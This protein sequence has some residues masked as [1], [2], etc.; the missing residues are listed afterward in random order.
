MATSA[1][2][3]ADRAELDPQST[4]GDARPRTVT[5]AIVTRIAARTPKAL[6]SSAATT[7]ELSIA[8]DY[9]RQHQE[10]SVGKLVEHLV[11]EACGSIDK[12]IFVSVAHR[13]R[14][15]RGTADGSGLHEFQKL[16]EGYCVWIE[17]VCQKLKL[18]MHGG[19]ACGLV[20]DGSLSP[21]Q[22]PVMTTNASIIVFPQRM[23]MLCHYFCKLLARSLSLRDIT[24]GTEVN[25][26]AKLALA[27]IAANKRL[28]RY[29]L[30][31]IAFN[32]TLNPRFL[33]PLK[34]AKGIARPVWRNLLIGTELFVLAHEYGHHLALHRTEDELD[35][36][37]SPSD[38]AKLQELE[39][40][41]LAAL[42]TAHFGAEAE[43]PIAHSCAAAVVA[44]VGTDIVRRARSVL[45]TGKVEEFRSETHPGLDERL[46]MLETLPYDARNT[47]AVRSMRQEFY[48]IMEGIWDMVVPDLVR[49]HKEG[50]RPNPVGAR[51]PPVL[52]FWG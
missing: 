6:L 24:D 15:L 27:K 8:R 47:E 14:S 31:F 49:M 46:S 51:Q 3:M 52:S 13:L 26:S 38:R 7:E 35:A 42:I 11:L 23:L 30:G 29:A 40:D 22:Q 25:F 37:L 10:R 17:H 16:L 44:L 9:L 28:R 1:E 19:L 21:A 39:A 41:H 12:E 36:D 20:W 50:V 4:E 33:K 32:A 48:A 34:N 5:E 43:L 45:L 2:E 18:S